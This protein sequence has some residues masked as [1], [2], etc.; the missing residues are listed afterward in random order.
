MTKPTLQ[1][2]QWSG[3]PG[4]RCWHHTPG[5]P[6]RKGDCRSAPDVELVW[7]TRNGLGARYYS[8]YAHLADSAA[9]CLGL[10]AQGRTI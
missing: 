7:A 10:A 3:P 2:S 6:S 9:L 5:K 1:L 4:F 8:C